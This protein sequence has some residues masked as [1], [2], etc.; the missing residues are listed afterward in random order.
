M[1][2]SLTGSQQVVKIVRDELVALLGEEGAE[3]RLDGRPAVVLLCGLQGSG[4][5][6]T[7]GKLAKRLR[8]AAAIRCWSPATSSAP[9]PSS[10]WCRS[11]AAS[12]CRW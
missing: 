11:A 7:A 5:T 12:A 6:T 2:A 4:K 8:G 9:P 1:L 10:S 3:L